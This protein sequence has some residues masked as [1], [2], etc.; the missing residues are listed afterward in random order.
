M[1]FEIAGEIWVRSAKL[2]VLVELTIN[3]YF[4]EH[5]ISYPFPVAWLPNAFAAKWLLWQMLAAHSS[6]GEPCLKRGAMLE[7]LLF[8][9]TTLVAKIPS[10]NPLGPKRPGQVTFHVSRRAH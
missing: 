6:A 4:Y 1:I 8:A 10:L 9:M 7:N 2:Q 3:C 5:K